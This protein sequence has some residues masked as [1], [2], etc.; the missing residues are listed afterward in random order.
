[1]TNKFPTIF[2]YIYCQFSIIHHKFYIFHI[3]SNLIFP[4]IWRKCPNCSYLHETPLYTN[5]INQSSILHGYPGHWSRFRWIFF[6]QKCIGYF[7]LI[8]VGT[9]H[10]SHTYKITVNRSTIYNSIGVI[11]LTFMV[12]KSFTNI[13][14][15]L[16]TFL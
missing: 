10:V 15:N 2:L 4:Y 5:R 16:K 6:F 3:S 14:K 1:M 9:V 12:H 11:V 7:I 13:S 8:Y